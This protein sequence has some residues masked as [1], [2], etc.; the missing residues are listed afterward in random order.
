MGT[1][2]DSGNGSDSLRPWTA[3]PNSSLV[4]TLGLIEGEILSY[5]EA[6]GATT[7]GRLMQDLSWPSQQIVMA[8]G[9]LLRQGLVS[10]VT[11]DFELVLDAV[12]ELE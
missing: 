11:R 12:P 3:M 8:I 5:V 2:M 4:T 9:A 1:W 6:H 7:L 10:G